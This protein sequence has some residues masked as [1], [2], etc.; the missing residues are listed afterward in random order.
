MQWFAGVQ[1]YAVIFLVG[2]EYK[3]VH[4]EV[5]I[6]IAS[7]FLTLLFQDL[8]QMHGYWMNFLFPSIGK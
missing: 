1:A 4:A 8:M 3:H 7:V 6:I 2:I 5:G